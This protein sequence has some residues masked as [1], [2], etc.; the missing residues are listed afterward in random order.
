MTPGSPDARAVSEVV[1]LYAA[2]WDEH[3][4]AARRELLERSWADAGVYCDPTAVVE[5]REALVAHLGAF[6]ASGAGARVVVTS[7][8]D[9]HDGFLR[10]A[11]QVVGADGSLQFEG[12][13]FGELDEDGR[14]RRIVGFFGPFPPADRAG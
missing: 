10:F 7:G 3:D 11:W 5:G 14:L 13:D 6:L 12:M 8:V 4:E 1:A 2:A 9:E